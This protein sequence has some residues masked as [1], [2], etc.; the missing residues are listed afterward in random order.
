MPTVHCRK[1]TTANLWAH[2]IVAYALAMAPMSVGVT[3]TR[4]LTLGHDERELAALGVE[5]KSQGG[6][7][8]SYVSFNVLRSS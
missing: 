5:A 7:K 1:A 2:D 3:L 6:S 4:C 8:L